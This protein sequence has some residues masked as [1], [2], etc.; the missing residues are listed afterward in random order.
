MAAVFFVVL[1]RWHV[2]DSPAVDGNKDHAD[3][4]L[5]LAAGLFV[6]AAVTD[7]L[8]GYFARAWRVVS[9]FGR[10]MDPLADKVLVLGGFM[11]LAGS[12]FTSRGFPRES[13][14]CV[15]PWMVI[16]LL[17]RELLVT[18][19]RAM[20]ESRGVSFAATASGKLK[21][22]L[23]SVCV[24]LVLVLIACADVRPDVGGDTHGD[25]WDGA[26][27]GARLL[28]ILIV[29]LTVIVTAWSGVPYV[30]RA[31]RALRQGP[32]IGAES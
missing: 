20:V 2:D 31:V 32:P 18:S 9:V 22:I 17:A 12:A 26:T 23:Q 6:C 19:L 3:M 11:L 4:W 7:A 15:E 24:P 29:H 14:S 16:V 8:D 28:I 5:L 10:V 30:I 27:P 21:M 1:S 25:G 13:F